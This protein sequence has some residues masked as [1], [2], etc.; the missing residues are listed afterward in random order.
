MRIG[1][2]AALAITVPAG[3]ALAASPTTVRV[4]GRLMVVNGQAEVPRG[5]FG[6]HASKLSAEIVKELGVECYRQI[7]F[8]PSSG[9]AA[10]TKEGRVKSPFDRMSFVI[11]C[12]GDRYCP[13]TVLSNPDY[14]AFFRRIGREYGETCKAA[15]WRGVA[16]FWNEPYLNWANRSYG[17]G[18]NHYH[19]KWYDVSKAVEG[20]PVTIQG[21]EKPLAHLK[22]KKLWP[23]GEDGKIGWGVA[24]PEGLGPGD[25]FR[26]RNRY[27]WTKNHE[28]TFTVVQEWH[29]HD[30]TQVDWWSGRQN[31]DFYLWMFLPWAEAMKEANPDVRIIAG[32]DFGFSH[33]DWAVF[34]E[35]VA[36]VID[37]GI[38]AL[39]GVTEHHY[40]VDSRAVT[41]WYEVA[42]AY[43]VAKHGKWIRGY[44]T[45]CDGKLDPA[46]HGRA[47]E[48]RETVPVNTDPASTYA[49][50][51]ILELACQAPAKAGART[52]HAV[53]PTGGVAEALRFLRPL[54]GPLLR[55]ERT[56]PD[57]WPV[58]CLAEDTIVV[59]VF[60]NAPEPREVELTLAAPKGT[61]LR[62]GT[63]AWIEVD[64]GRP[65][66]KDA[67]LEAGGREVTL[68]RALGPRQAVRF[69]LPLRGAPPQ[70]P[71]IQR[72]QFFAAEGVLH[73]VAPGKPVTLHVPVEAAYAKGTGWARLKLVLEGVKPGEGSVTLNGTRL[74]LGGRNWTVE[75]PLDAS[76]VRAE[77]TLVFTADGSEADGYRVCVASLLL[78]RPHP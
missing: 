10:L 77:N 49:L 34:R 28:Q 44:N 47:A 22:W 67:P 52:A 4:D 15:G 41:A 21:W 55:T 69:I 72:R 5:L 38:A 45:E 48:S 24:I 42:T 78:E 32:W 2:V 59:V 9:C 66:V 73:D 16:E 18:R 54:R 1:L 75:L 58:A 19:N 63:V 17:S 26:G 30:P 57:V 23:K 25:T 74:D 35:L 33:G 8:G 56:D 37:Q 36:P 29:V 3:L 70:A 51:D 61:E 68:T 31:L 50:R 40:G 62:K 14:E 76:L 39:D 64:G 65:R 46:V 43:A 20:G 11:D 12:Q 6:L 71:D 27:Y 53:S 13:A 60:S 7:H